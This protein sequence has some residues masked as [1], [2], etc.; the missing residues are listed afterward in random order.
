MLWNETKI[1]DFEIRTE[2]QFPKLLY[3]ERTEY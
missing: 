3:T 2:E 1:Y